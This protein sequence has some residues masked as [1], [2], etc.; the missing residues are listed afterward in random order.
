[1]SGRTAFVI[2]GFN[3]YHSL[4][5]ASA[6]LGLPN[7]TGT[8]WLNLRGLCASY[9]PLFGPSATLKD[10]FYFSALAHHL[11]KSKPGVTR[12][13]RHYADVLEQTGVIVEFGRFKKK[14]VKCRLCKK[15][16]ERH[17]EKETDVALSV[18]VLELFANNA[19]DRVVL[20]TGDTDVAPAVRLA[21]K[22]YPQGEVCFIFP[23]KRKQAELAKLV[24]TSFTISTTAYRT[25]QFADPAVIGSKTFAKPANW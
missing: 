5:E 24:N 11:E 7:E 8:K 19:A 16:F 21:K 3:V 20:V 2:D 18:K 13:H 22:L 10:V 15:V 12:R 17:E 14:I 4:V 23:W 6:S 1:M 9:I 25:H